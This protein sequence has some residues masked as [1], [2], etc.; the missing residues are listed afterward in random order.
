MRRG[1]DDTLATLLE[2]VPSKK[3]LERFDILIKRHKQKS[4]A[5]FDLE[6]I[7]TNDDRRSGTRSLDG[8]PKSP[9]GAAK[10]SKPQARFSLVN[11]KAT[12]ESETTSSNTA[13]WL[14]LMPFAT[15]WRETQKIRKSKLE[16]G[17][18]NDTVDTKKLDS[19]KLP[20]LKGQKSDKP[21]IEKSHKPLTR[22]SSATGYRRPASRIDFTRSF[23]RSP[24]RIGAHSSMA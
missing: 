20:A 3:R 13:L 6:P 7:I 14:Q 2:Q 4:R 1:H 18:F 5:G 9:V 8:S 22:S 16:E 19:K 11:H 15:G 17:G 23:A 12:G 21:E 24:T 10:K